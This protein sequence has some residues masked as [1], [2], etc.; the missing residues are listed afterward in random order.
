MEAYDLKPLDIFMIEIECCTHICMLLSRDHYSKGQTHSW[1]SENYHT[2]EM[3]EGEYWCVFSSYKGM[4]GTHHF[5]TD[6][7]VLRGKYLG[8]LAALLDR[9]G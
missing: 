6:E 7:E 3:V 9:K 2:T 4:G 8:N 5:L 1:D